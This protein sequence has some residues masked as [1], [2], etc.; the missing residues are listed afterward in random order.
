MRQ[1]RE[2]FARTRRSTII[3]RNARTRDEIRSCNPL[4]LLCCGL[5][6]TH[7]NTRRWDKTSVVGNGNALSVTLY[8]NGRP[9]PPLLLFLLPLLLVPHAPPV[10]RAK[11][12]NKLLYS[13]NIGGV[14]RRA[15]PQSPHM[16]QAVRDPL[17]NLHFNACHSSIITSGTAWLNFTDASPSPP[18][19]YPRQAAHS[20]DV[21]LFL[22]LSLFEQWESRSLLLPGRTDI[23]DGFVRR[24]CCEISLRFFCPSILRIKGIFERYY[25]C[26][27][28]YGFVV[29]KISMYDIQRVW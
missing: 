17:S 29:W 2:S 8:N 24:S 25:I 10:H 12:Q 1:Q 27:F 19:P 5:V 9:S 14:A 22:S 7:N 21:S 20:V 4:S 26:L 23:Y 3:S 13:A 28:T 6:L 15:K 16:Y 18:L 11:L